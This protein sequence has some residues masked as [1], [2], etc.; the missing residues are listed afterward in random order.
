MGG[1]RKE[2]VSWKGWDG[3]LL[4]AKHLREEEF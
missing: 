4:N 3:W 1:G 2:S